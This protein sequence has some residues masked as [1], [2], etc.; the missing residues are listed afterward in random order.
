MYGGADNDWLIA[1]GGDAVILD[2]GD[3]SDL[4]VGWSGEDHLYGNSG[5]GASDNEEDWYFISN[6]TFIHNAG[7]E[8]HVFLGPFLATGGRPGLSCVNRCILEAAR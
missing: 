6:N 7:V 3:G 5:E 1:V 2:G 4:L 8:D